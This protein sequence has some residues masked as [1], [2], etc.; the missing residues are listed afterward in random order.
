[1]KFEAVKCDECGRIQ[2]E[3]NHWVHIQAWLD[4]NNVA[5]CYGVAL[6]DVAEGAM[7]TGVFTMA[8]KELLDLCGQGCAMKKVAKLL[9][10]SAPGVGE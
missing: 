5:Q 10:W 8:K 4:K 7:A 3:A 2:G 1:M 6:G 9:G